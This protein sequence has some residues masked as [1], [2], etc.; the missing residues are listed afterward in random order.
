MLKSIC[1]AGAVLY[2]YMYS[3]RRCGIESPV[4]ANS[5][6]CYPESRFFTDVCPGRRRDIQHTTFSCMSPPT[7]RS[8][9]S[10]PVIIIL[11]PLFPE[12]T[13]LCQ[14]PFVK[15]DTPLWKVATETR[16]HWGGPAR[17][18][19]SN[20]RVP[21]DGVDWVDKEALWLLIVEK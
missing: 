14:C 11:S 3:S 9:C 15:G 20:E 17:V 4:S 8:R 10:E 19:T 12:Y 18:A 5:R 7:I 21:N 2:M 16:K 1:R 13:Q 6:D